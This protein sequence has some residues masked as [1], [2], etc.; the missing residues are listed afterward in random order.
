MV[1]PPIHIDAAR[2]T[3]TFAFGN[4]HIGL[5]PASVV[6]D[7]ETATGAVYNVLQNCGGFFKEAAET[8]V[9]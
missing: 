6:G 4:V 2:I 9:G 3:T 5:L 8:L 1:A 7:F